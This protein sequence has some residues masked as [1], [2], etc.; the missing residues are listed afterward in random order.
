MIRSEST[1]TICDGS[2]LIIAVATSSWLIRGSARESAK[3]T[4]DTLPAGMPWRHPAG[5]R[6]HFSAHNVRP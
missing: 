6:S 4:R 2:Q 3:A 1:A 5:T